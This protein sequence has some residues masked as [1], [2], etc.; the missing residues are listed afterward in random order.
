MN[1]LLGQYV[2]SSG[3][4]VPPDW[5]S[6]TRC[7]PMR[8]LIYLNIF[9]RQHVPIWKENCLFA[10]H[11]HMS[12]KKWLTAPFMV[13]WI[14]LLLYGHV[15]Q[16][17]FLCSI[18]VSYILVNA[19]YLLK[20]DSHYF[21]YI[22]IIKSLQSLH[23][24]QIIFWEV[25]QRTY[26]P[27]IAM[28]RLLM[29]IVKHKLH[30]LILHITKRDIQLEHLIMLKIAT[31]Q[32]V[33]TLISTFVSLKTFS[34]SHPKKTLVSTLSSS[35]CWLL[36]LAITQT[37]GAQRTK[38]I[39]TKNV[40]VTQLVGEFDDERLKEKLQTCKY[41]LVNSEMQNGRHVVFIFA[42]E[43]LVAHTLTKKLDILFVKLK[44]AA[45]LYLLFGFVLKI[46]RDGTCRY[47][48]AH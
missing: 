39:A 47:Y 21:V 38:S 19:I 23:F 2:T 12:F 16:S 14:N 26:L 25:F 5:F 17:L 4:F 33:L 27:I 40:D 45:K 1:T 28:T 6:L 48:Y 35:F 36:S 41:F 24:F 10:P 30:N 11:D 9:L 43:I 20:V 34:L 37:E 13:L 3:A 8:N 15:N 42:T 31:S 22:V 29:K 44:Y 18:R 7:R 32:Q 46:V